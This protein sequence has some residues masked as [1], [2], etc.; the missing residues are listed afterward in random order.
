MKK[1][2]LKEKLRNEYRV[3]NHLKLIKA[4]IKGYNKGQVINK[5]GVLE[6]HPSDICDLNCFYCT[7][8]WAVKGLKM[9]EKIYPYKKL[10]KIAI[11]KP[12]AIVVVGGGE[13]TLYKDGDK[14]FKDLIYYLS[15]NIPKVK[16]G[17]LTNGVRIPPGNWPKYVEWVRVSLDA[18]NEKTFRMLKDG[19]YY[20]RILTIL[21][22]LESPIK[23]VGVGYVYNRFNI[24]EIPEMIKNIYDTVVENLGENYLKK[25]NV[26]FRPTCP[27]ESCDCPSKVYGEKSIIMT[28][29]LHNWWRK[30]VA[31]VSTKIENL[32][33][34]KNMADF[35][36]KNTN[37]YDLR[38]TN[39]KVQP[40]IFKH[41]YTAL[42]R[43]ILRPN[44][45]VYPCV[46]KASNRDKKIGNIL[47]EPLSRLTSRSFEFYKLNE[48]YC[49]GTTECC[50]MAGK[51]NQIVENN[52]YS[53]R[54]PREI[55]KDPFF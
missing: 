18:A 45:D 12:K 42:V 4:K 35:I 23:F 5:I 52:L 19:E 25:L 26:Q 54:I 16:I 28:P 7:Y 6:F 27:V 11:L 37:V 32:K 30:A 49:K 46:M 36:E 38:S 3:L 22:Y 50:R 1:N 15:K 2:I 9:E 24:Y 41:C 29:D 33:K 40:P 13:P 34:N 44:G 8:R 17:L 51:L 31:E 48:N 10:N 53:T 14:E 21:K 47:K 20:T 43:W 39:R 55:P